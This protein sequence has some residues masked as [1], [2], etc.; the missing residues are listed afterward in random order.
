MVPVFGDT[1]VGFAT[2][3]SNSGDHGSRILPHLS[4]SCLRSEDKGDGEFF[5]EDKSS[6][7]VYYKSETNLT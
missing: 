2:V 1:L 3:S 5:E 6:T 7:G 4:V